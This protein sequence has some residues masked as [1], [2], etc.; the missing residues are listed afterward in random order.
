MSDISIAA[1][2]GYLASVWRENPAT[3]VP[4]YPLGSDLFLTSYKTDIYG[5]Q[6]KDGN[7]NPIVTSSIDL[8]YSRDFWT[9]MMQEVFPGVTQVEFNRDTAS[10]IANPVNASQIISQGGYYVALF[11]AAAKDFYSAFFLGRD[12]LNYAGSTN[13][14]AIDLSQWNSLTAIQK[15]AIIVSYLRTRGPTAATTTSLY[16]GNLNLRYQNI[17]TWVASLLIQIM[18]DLQSS[19][20]NSGRLSTRLA[21]TTQ[22]I[23]TEMGSSA[24]DYISV[25]DP[26]DY[27]TQHQNAVNT[28]T[29]EDLRTF[30]GLLQSQT[31]QASADLTRLNNSVEQQGDV[32]LRF[33]DQAQKIAERIWQTQ[34][35]GR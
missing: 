30:R 2:D 7:G 15:Q 26:K 16:M 11:Q 24:Y 5:A 3:L 28:K 23:S 17:L 9:Y 6:V 10:Q 14:P 8:I 29:L 20:I 27:S 19:T 18:S 1:N 21:Q 4:N 33:A 13:I 31:D 34:L 25:T 12:D 35:R 32:A 22:S